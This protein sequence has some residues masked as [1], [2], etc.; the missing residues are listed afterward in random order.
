MNVFIAYR[1]EAYEMPFHALACF[2]T[3]DAAESFNARCVAHDAKRPTVPN[4]E[5]TDNWS[6]QDWA[7]FNG[8]VDRWI[9]RHPGKLYSPP[10]GY[11]ILEMKVRP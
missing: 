7:S 9:K 2:A 3:R 11:D 1:F 8:K 4:D 6:T 5:V 10:D